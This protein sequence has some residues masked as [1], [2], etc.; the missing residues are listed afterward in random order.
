LNFLIMARSEPP[1]AFL[2]SD[3]SVTPTHAEAIKADI[4]PTAIR[5]FIQPLLCEP[6]VRFIR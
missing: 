1:A 4:A 2:S 5:R 6:E 3:C